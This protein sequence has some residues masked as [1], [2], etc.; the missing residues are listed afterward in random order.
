[1]VVVRCRSQATAKA[2]VKPV[3]L[4]V[5]GLVPSAAAREALTMMAVPCGVAGEVAVMARELLGAAIDRD[6]DLTDTPDY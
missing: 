2:V 3:G 5:M 1:M 6:C 4:K